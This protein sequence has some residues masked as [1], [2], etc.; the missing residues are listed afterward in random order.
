MPD[1]VGLLAMGL[2]ASFVLLVIEMSFPQMALFHDIAN[3]VR[4]V[5]FQKAVLE[6]MLAFL[7]FAGALHVNLR[8]LRDRAWVVG[9]IATFG[10][11]LSTAIVGFGLF[12]ASALLGT[13]I[14][15]T[16]ALVFGTLISPTDPVA[17]LST[18][19]PFVFRSHSRWT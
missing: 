13:P 16:W 19:K 11:L 15:L 10:V 9:G 4:Q 8:A 3:I 6:G 5:D 7:L 14:P 18:S 2:V 17:V 12:H 1:T